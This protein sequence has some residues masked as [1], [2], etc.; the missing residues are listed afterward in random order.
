VAV[1]NHL[2]SMKKIA[3]AIIVSAVLV[4]A[5]WAQEGSTD[6]DP[7]F[8]GEKRPT[9]PA[10]APTGDAWGRDPFSNPLANRAPI[11]KAQGTDILG[12]GLTGIIYSQD[13]RLAII[14]GEALREGSSVGDRKLVLIKERSVKLANKVGGIEEVFLQDFSMRK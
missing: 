7:F 14:N 5:V 13:V 3:Y 4:S 9:A 1:T 8:P 11:R 10:M 2:P 12:K 6:R